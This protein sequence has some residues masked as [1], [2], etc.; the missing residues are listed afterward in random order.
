ML[1]LKLCRHVLDK[2]IV[3]VFSAEMVVTARRYYLVLT[4][5]NLHN[6]DIEGTASEIED[7]YMAVVGLSLLLEAISE[8]SSCGLVYDAENLK[9]GYVSSI[10][11]CLTLSVRKVGRD[12]DDAFSHRLVK[13]L[14]SRIFEFGKD[15]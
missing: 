2:G 12:R 4:V 7:K 14:L 13:V 5:F 8:G 11:C 10:P 6:C 1:L 3:E 15:H 9:P